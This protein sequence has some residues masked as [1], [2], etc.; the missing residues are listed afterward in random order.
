[1]NGQ[2]YVYDAWNRLVTVKNSSSI[3]LTSYSY[4][5]LDRRITET[6]DST[7][8]ARYYSAGWQLLEE[9][10]DGDTAAR[11]V[12]SPV[13]VDALVLRDRDT[14]NDGVPD[15]RLY[16]LQDANW[17]VTALVNTSGDV[18]ERYTYEPFGAVTVL[19]PG[20]TARGSSS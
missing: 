16:A 2:Q 3:T 18:V 4:D 7:T 13:Y 14:N 10:I 15:Q 17:N 19:T 6:V 12:W 5:G 11:Y 8:S 20:W 9:Q 1:E